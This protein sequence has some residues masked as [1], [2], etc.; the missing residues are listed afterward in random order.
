MVVGL[1]LG[2][3]S[4]ILVHLLYSHLVDSTRTGAEARAD[5]LASLMSTAADPDNPSFTSLDDDEDEFVQV[6]DAQGRVVAA[7]KGMTGQPAVRVSDEDVVS[8]PFDSDRFAVAGS[9]VTTSLGDRTV[10]VGSSLEG[11]RDAAD[12]LTNLLLVGAPL[13]MLVVGATTWLVV[14]RTLAP[15]E[16]IR[17][18]ADEITGTQLHRRLPEPTARDEIGRLTRTMNLMLARLDQAQQQQQRFVSDAAHELRS[19][20]ASIRQN[21]EVATLYPDHL[22][23]E[24]LIETVRSEST[25]LER[26]VTALLSLARL[27]ERSTSTGA[28]PVD[29]DDLVFE[30]SRRLRQSTSLRIDTTG[31]GAGR[32]SVDAALLTQMLRNL[33]DNAERHAVSVIALSLAEDDATVVLTVEDDGPGVEPVDR[34]R[35][36]DRFVRLDDARAR[37]DGGSGLGLAIVH[38]I[39]VA[40]GG[41]VTLTRSRLGGARLLVR[42][43]RLGDNA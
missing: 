12:S 29:L 33:V 39:V 36:F 16:R 25:R 43:P 11:A 3:G 31:V 20:V 28:D 38:D 9:E 18:E 24:E 17:R 40:H 10:I 13:M 34:E 37:D 4:V 2:T 19:P 7:S 22:S 41:S 15:V 23:T 8:V 5:S 35:V 42:L 26:L 21:L 27:D 30:E 14:G 6:L 32:V 1:A